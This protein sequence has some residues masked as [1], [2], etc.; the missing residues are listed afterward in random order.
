[1]EFWDML[2]RLKSEGIT[3]LVSTAYM[4]EASLCDRIALMRE[5]SFIATDTPQN[6]IN[7]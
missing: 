4:D 2:E 3:V 5:G 7:R 1:K 6:I